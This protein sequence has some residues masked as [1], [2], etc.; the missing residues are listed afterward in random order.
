M[1]LPYCALRLVE[2]LDDE[3]LLHLGGAQVGLCEPLAD[4]ARA[5]GPCVRRCGDWHVCQEQHGVWKC[6]T[7]GDL[8]RLPDV[9]ISMGTDWTFGCRRELLAFLEAVAKVKADFCVWRQGITFKAIKLNAPR[10]PVQRPGGPIPVKP[11][12]G[13]ILA[14]CTCLVRM[15]NARFAVYVWLLDETPDQEQPMVSL[16]LQGVDVNTAVEERFEWVVFRARCHLDMD[17]CSQ[18]NPYLR[19]E[20]WQRFLQTEEQPLLP[21]FFVAELDD[22]D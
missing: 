8:Q 11:P 10:P 6:L 4:A 16:R 2:G 20:V 21:L 9:E 3:S 12:E 14:C 18:H 7:Q 15:Q 5:S 22:L 13:R 19:R 1:L 17:Y